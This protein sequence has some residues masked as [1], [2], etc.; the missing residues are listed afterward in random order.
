MYMYVYMYMYIFI[1]IGAGGN[2]VFLE[3]GA[4][5]DGACCLL[6]SWLAQ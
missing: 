4:I 1:Y 6:D 2:T 5:P 3:A